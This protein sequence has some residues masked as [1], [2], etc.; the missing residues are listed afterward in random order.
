MSKLKRLKRAINSPRAQA[1]KRIPE[2][3]RILRRDRNLDWLGLMT[4]YEQFAPTV[5]EYEWAKAHYGASD[6]WVDDTLENLWQTALEHELQEGV[7][8]AQASNMSSIQFMVNAHFLFLK[9]GAVTIELTE[10][11]T[12]SLLLTASPGDL[13]DINLENFPW[14]AFKLVIPKGVVPGHGGTWLKGG[15]AFFSVEKGGVFIAEDT[16]YIE[17]GDPLCFQNNEI[18]HTPEAEKALRLLANNLMAMVCSEPESFIKDEK[19]TRQL[20]ATTPLEKL[21]LPAPQVYVANPDGIWGDADLNR[22]VYQ[23]RL[24]G[25]SFK[26]MTWFRRGHW[27]MQP[28][29]RG[30]KETKRIRVAPSW[31]RRHATDGEQAPDLAPD[32]QPESCPQ[33]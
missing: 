29:G 10:E 13:T 23:Q 30:L 8:T 26:T 18:P 6:P 33:T 11:T 15:L 24:S 4:L 9:H 31:C 20:R 19:K 17:D 21:H 14:Q 25:I 32:S 3:K 5:A 2:I 16:Y 28:F 12:I 27:R 22:K 7:D 1:L